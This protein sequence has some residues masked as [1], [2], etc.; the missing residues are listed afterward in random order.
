MFSSP[1]P[2][3]STPLAL[4]AAAFGGLKPQTLGRRSSSSRW[5]TPKAPVGVGQRGFPA[6]PTALLALSGRK[7]PST[8]IMLILGDFT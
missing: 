8:P 5:V 6:H 7:Q 3:C 2:S 4:P 1:S